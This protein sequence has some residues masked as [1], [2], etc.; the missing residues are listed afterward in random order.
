MQGKGHV[1]LKKKSLVKEIFHQLFHASGVIKVKK[2]QAAVNLLLFKKWR[3][4]Q[5]C[6]AGQI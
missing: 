6:L 1:D 5:G 4:T 3:V 2:W